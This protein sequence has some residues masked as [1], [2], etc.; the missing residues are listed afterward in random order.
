[1][2]PGGRLGD[3]NEEDFIQA[4]RTGVRPDGSVMSQEMPWRYFTEMTDVEL[5]ALWMYLGSLTPSEGD[6]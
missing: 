3:W 6:S 1:M 2:T 4:L 5:K